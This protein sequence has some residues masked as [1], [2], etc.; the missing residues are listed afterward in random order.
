M[1]TT[2]YQGSKRRVLP[3]L[4][5]VFSA[6]KFETCLD[7]FGGTGSVTHLLRRMGKK[8]TYNDI[9]PANAMIAK[10]LF[11]PGLCRL[12]EQKLDRLFV[13][14][15][16]RKYQTFIEE[17]YR[18]IYYLD[19]ENRELD[20]IARNILDLED[21]TEKAEA[22]YVLFQSMLCKRPYNLFHRANLHM[23]M[24]DVKRS[25]GNKATWERPFKELMR[26]FFKELREYRA[27]GSGKPVTVRSGSAFQVKKKF[28]LVY[29]DTPYA[30]SDAV[31]E[32]NYF[33]FYHFL[34]AIIEHSSLPS[35]IKNSSRHK[36]IYEVNQ[37]W[38]SGR[39]LLE[40]FEALFSRFAPSQLVIS[41]RSDG[42]PSPEAILK[43]LRKFY[44]KPVI[45]SLAEYRYVLST[46]RK[47]TEEI[48]FVCRRSKAQDA[49]TQ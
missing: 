7:A 18:G 49:K 31:Q 29:I 13:R 26:R 14:R 39:D 4:Y 41:Y 40:A 35:L 17:N 9:L 15:K 16:N 27:G 6:L 2:R 48:V 8:V 10:A 36:A 24:A 38:H 5:K 44:E 23:R 12:N 25:F 43:L 34:D 47:E 3:E 22:Y 33:N 28:D 11:S 45:H 1:P 32:S 37:S 30:K 20:T 19:R 42:Y 21:K 46:A